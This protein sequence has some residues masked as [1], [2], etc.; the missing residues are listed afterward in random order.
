MLREPLAR[1]CQVSCR[2]ER[3]LRPVVRFRDWG[4]VQS[5]YVQSAL[6]TYNLTTVKPFSL[7]LEKVST[8]T[9]V[10]GTRLQCLQET[11]APGPDTDGVLPVTPRVLL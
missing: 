4:I 2:G 3:K 7:L 5:A 6:S 9:I 10:G 11:E 8:T 1:I